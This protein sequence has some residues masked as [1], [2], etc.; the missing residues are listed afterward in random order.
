MTTEKKKTQRGTEISDLPERQVSTEMEGK[1]TGGRR[2]SAAKK[3]AFKKSVKRSPGRGGPSG[4][5]SA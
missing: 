5:D 3:A 1:V 4:I 2:K